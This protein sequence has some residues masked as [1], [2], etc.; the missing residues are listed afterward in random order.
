METWTKEKI[1]CL[2]NSNPKAV[3]KALLVLFNRQTDTEQAAEDTKFVNM[4]GFT[5]A[6][7]PR[8]SSIAKYLIRRK[9]LTEK[10]VALVRRRI[11]KYWKQLLQEVEIKGGKVKY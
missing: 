10:Q 7:A 11:M 2:L 8:L 5:A 4:R 6:D 9:S 1:H 3:E